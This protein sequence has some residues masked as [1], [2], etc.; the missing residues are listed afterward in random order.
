MGSSTAFP[1]EPM[2]EN[3]PRETARRIL[4]VEDDAVLRSLVRTILDEDGYAV[5]EVDAPSA[6]AAILRQA[7]FDLIITDGFAVTPTIGELGAAD[8]IREA[9]GTPVALFTAQTVRREQALAAG[10][11]ELIEKPFDLDVF[12]RRVRALVDSAD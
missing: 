6:A 1:E 8:L 10:F 9:G 5:T 7:A 11:R 12:E 3:C 2:R 4:L